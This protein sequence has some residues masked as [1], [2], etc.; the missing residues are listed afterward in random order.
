[1]ASQW[2]DYPDAH[3]KMLAECRAYINAAPTPQERARRKQQ[4][5]VHIYSSSEPLSAWLKKEK[6]Q[7]K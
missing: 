3:Y 7:K 4:M 6:E 1:M 5:Y 2:K